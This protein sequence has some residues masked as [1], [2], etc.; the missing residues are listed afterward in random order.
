MSAGGGAFVDVDGLEEALGDVH[1]TGGFE[2]VVEADSGHW[3]VVIWGV[4]LMM[5]GVRNISIE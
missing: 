4:K 1:S 2:T 3:G 5:F